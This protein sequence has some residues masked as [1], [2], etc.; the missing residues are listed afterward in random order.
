MLR[1]R[2]CRKAAAY[3]PLPAHNNCYGRIDKSTQNN[4]CNTVAPSDDCVSSIRKT[5]PSLDS[6]N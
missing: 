3:H 4:S 2:E 6:G 1:N 5:S